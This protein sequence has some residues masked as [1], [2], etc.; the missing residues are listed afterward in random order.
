MGFCQDSTKVQGLA[1]Q[2][3]NCLLKITEQGINFC[4]FLYLFKLYVVQVEQYH[5]AIKASQK[6]LP[7]SF[8]EENLAF[9]LSIDPTWRTW[10]FATTESKVNIII[11]L[12][13]LAVTWWHSMNDTDSTASLSGSSNKSSLATF[14]K[15]LKEKT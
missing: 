15:Q 14:K 12:I 8:P 11:I 13:F 5:Q 3:W 4:D 1:K 10:N 2:V 6:I 9:R 7:L